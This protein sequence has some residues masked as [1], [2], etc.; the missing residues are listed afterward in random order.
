MQARRERITFA[1]ALFMAGAGAMSGVYMGFALWLLAV[2]FFLWGRDPASIEGLVARLPAGA[3]LKKALGHLDSILAMGLYDMQ[4]SQEA[5]G[6]VLSNA[7]ELAMRPVKS[8]EDVERLAR[9]F[10]LFCSAWKVELT[11]HISVAE[12][13]VLFSKVPASAIERV[14][15]VNDK[16]NRILHALEVITERLHHLI[17]ARSS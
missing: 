1:L 5:L 4:K 7:T 11:P 12:M 14:G 15:G 10:Q 9:D 8:P 16:H 3:H 17:D 13:A 2:F 6:A